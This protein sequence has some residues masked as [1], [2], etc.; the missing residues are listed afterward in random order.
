MFSSWRYPKKL[1]W[2]RPYRHLAIGIM[3]RSRYRLE[4]GTLGQMYCI[5][6]LLRLAMSHHSHS[7]CRN[8]ASMSVFR[9]F[10]FNEFLEDAHS[11]LEDAHSYLWMYA[12]NWIC[13]T[14]RRFAVIFS[15]ENIYA[16]GNSLPIHA[17]DIP[18]IHFIFWTALGFTVL[19]QCPFD[20][21]TVT[22]AMF[23]VSEP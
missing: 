16:Y 13:S 6:C 11:F 10:F 14:N 18:V 9:W 4:W 19:C 23:F 1:I 17:Y 20:L 12:C 21:G 8:N 7:L 15:H 3:C 5:W 2:H 22:L